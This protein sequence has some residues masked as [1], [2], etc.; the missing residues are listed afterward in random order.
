MP[1]KYVHVREYTVRA[2]NRLLKTRVYK[3]ICK[4]CDNS[5]EREVYGKCPTYCVECRPPKQPKQ[6]EMKG[7]RIPRRGRPRPRL[8]IVDKAS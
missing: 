7:R 2:H 5:T 8:T 3:F 1:S 6:I 4:Q